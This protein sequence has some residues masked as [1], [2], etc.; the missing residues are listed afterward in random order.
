MLQ[1]ES[2]KI[3]AS[4]EIQLNSREELWSFFKESTIPE[5]EKE[6]NLGL[7][8]RGSQLARILAIAEIYKEIINIPG[9]IFD[10]GS[11]RGQNAVL[12]EN[13]RAIHEPFNKQRKIVCFDT[14][15]GYTSQSNDER[16]TD[17]FD[18]GAYSVESD[19]SDTL[20]Y[21]LKLH[22]KNNILP[23]IHGIHQVVKGDVLT[24]LPQ[25]FKKN[26]ETLISLAFFDMNLFEPTSFAMKTILDRVVPSGL[27]CFYQLQRDILPGEALTYL[28]I[29]PLLPKHKLIKSSFYPTMCY[30]KIID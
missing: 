22:E 2:T 30:I 16:K 19:Y 25:Y 3:S 26:P 6:R 20:D 24:T 15:T 10:F 17:A 12:C 1:S 27:L 8:I 28:D 5:S 14:F 23:H 13:L 21:L 4:N 29:K 9:H 7:F 18:K 11:W